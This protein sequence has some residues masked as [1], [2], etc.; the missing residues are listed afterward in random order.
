MHSRKPPPAT[1][2]H[3]PRLAGLRYYDHQDHTASAYFAQAALADYWGR[4]TERPAI[5]ENYLGYEVGA[6]PNNL[7]LATARRKAELLSVYGWADQRDCGDPAGCGDRKVGGTAFSR[8]HP[9]LDPL[10]PAARPRLQRLDPPRQGRPARR[11][12][13]PGRRGV[14]LGRDRPGQ[15]H[16]PS[17]RPRAA[18]SC[19]RGRSTWCGSPDGTLQLFAARTVLPGRNAAH[20][21]EVMTAVQTRHPPDGVPAFARWES[22]GLPRP[23]TR[24]GRWRP[25]SRRRSPLR[26]APCTSSYGPGTA[27]SPTAADRAA[28][29]CRCGSGLRPRPGSRR[30]RRRSSTGSMRRGLRRAD[31]SGRARAAGPCSTGCRRSRADPPQP[32]AATGL[33]EAGRAG[34]RS[35]R[36]P[37]AWCVSPTAAR[38]PRRY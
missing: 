20:R 2:D 8:R 6:L 9:E 16:F 17:A 33:P 10:H 38:T 14:L 35:S 37:A 34:Q 22:A 3:D 21:R 15:R 1:A 5:V 7:D 13:G 24:S 36:W 30:R 12:R 27:T 29:P 4:S 26:T 19:C 31:P 28:G 23:V 18:A 32:A 11:L 25:A